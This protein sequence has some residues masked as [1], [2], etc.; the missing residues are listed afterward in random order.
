MKLLSVNVSLPKPV[1]HGD[2]TVVTGIFKEPVGGPVML[3]RLNLEGDGQADPQNHGGEYKAVY[4]YAIEHYE[5]WKRELGRDGFPPGQF[6]ENFTVQ[7][8]TEDDIHIG[9]AFR[10][11]SALIQVTQPRSPCYKLAVKMGLPNFPKQFLASG[12][13]G[14]YLRVL[15]EG[16]VSAGDAVERV[17]VDP[18]RLTVREMLRLLYAERDDRAA[19]ERALRIQALS[20]RRRAAFQERLRKGGE[21]E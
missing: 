13:V 8:M 9:D 20:P 17:L 16:E 15:E 1:A 6:G 2:E 11:G 3:R 18:E 4:A 12:R 7:G 10:V 5:F 14:F 19:I 21:C